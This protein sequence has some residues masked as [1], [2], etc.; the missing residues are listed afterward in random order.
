[1]I[2]IVFLLNLGANFSLNFSDDTCQCE[3]IDQK[4]DTTCRLANQLQSW[5]GTSCACECPNYYS[6]DKTNCAYVKS[7]NLPQW[8]NTNKCQ[9]ECKT[10]P[11]CNLFSQ[12]YNP[13][14]CACDCKADPT[15]CDLNFAWS[16]SAC[17][18]TKC[19]ACATS[20]A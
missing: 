5:N 6:F 10:T 15:P 17:T 18:C 20:P 19:N 3:C 16:K 12:K 1:M 11:T 14:T 2:N 13:N 9:C 4:D 7:S 8:F